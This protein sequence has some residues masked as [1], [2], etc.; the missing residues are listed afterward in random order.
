MGFE[1]DKIDM[2]SEI[3]YTEEITKCTL[4]QK[5][6]INEDCQ[7]VHIELD[8]MRTFTHYCCNDCFI[9]I[10]G[11]LERTLNTIKN[12]ESEY[13]KHWNAYAIEKHELK[14]K[15]WFR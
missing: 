7:K 9:H 2:D 11:A 1:D 4:C 10:L 6:K 5:K 13:E 15:S 8:K 14:K 12:I 3:E